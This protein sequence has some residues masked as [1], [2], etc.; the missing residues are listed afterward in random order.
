MTD[1]SLWEVILNGDSPV[2]TRVVEGVLQPVASTTDEHWLARKNEL[3]ACGTAL[4]NLAFVSS[5]HTDSTT[6]SVSAAASIFAACAKLPASPLP[7]VDS[8]KI[9]LRWQMAMLTMQ[10][11]RFLQK[12]GRNLGENGPTSM[13]LDMSK[14]ECYNCRRKGHFAREC[15][16]LKD[17][18]RPGVA[19]PQRRTVPVETLTSNALVSQCNGT[20]SYDW[21]YQA[22]EDPV[23]F[24]LMAFSLNSSSDNETG[25][26]SVE[27]RLLVYKQNE[28]VFEEN[29]KLL[30]IEVELR[31]TAL[32][33]LRHKLEKA[34]Q[35]RDDLKLKLEKF[36]TSS[37]NLT[38]LLASQTNEKPGLG[39]NS[40][41]S[42]T[43][44][45]QDL[46]H[47]TRPSAPIIEDWVS[48][49]KDESETKATQF[50]PSFAESSEHVKSLRHSNQPIETTI[51][52]ATPVHSSPKSNSSGKKRNKKACFVC[53]SVDNLIKDCDYHTKKMA[54]PIPRTY[55]YRGHYKK[56]APLTYS[57]PQK[58]MV[59]PLV[60]TQS[61]PVSNTVIR[62]VSTA[63]P[64]IFVTRPRYAHHVVTKS[65]SPIR[66]H[67]TCSPTLKTST[68]PPRVTTI[69]ASVVSAAQ[70]KQGTWVWRPKCPIL[71]HDFRTT[72]ASMTL[73]WF[74]Y[75]DALGRSN[76]NPNGGK[77][78]GKGKIKTG[79]LDFD[80]VYFVKELKFNLFSVS[81]MCDKKNSVLFTDTEC[82]VLSP[83]FKLSD[84]NQ[85]LHRVPR[86]NNMYNVNLKHIIPSGDLT[87]L[88]AKATLDESNLWHRRLGHIN[89]KTINKLVKGNL[90][91]GLP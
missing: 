27:A 85:V 88:F 83:D 57:K 75:N 55:A 30:N 37:K 70:G 21:S 76:G 65:K 49:S 5:S 87:C 34:K 48:D 40:Q 33:T 24:A 41:L 81:Q 71:D 59:P 11:R 46:S 89:F 29:I 23:N 38:D 12:T 74:D 82:L 4:Q 52:A 69:K 25:L 17:P 51:P 8:L 91:R 19:E 2:P 67:I 1:Y 53:K 78:T 90:V 63:L 20:G 9:D 42:P 35:E 13:G 43:K 77:N 6:D 64:N 36:Q 10:A 58:H 50:V 7:N 45:E 72:S 62:P 73:K 26:E 3:K 44:P 79:K 28:S 61:K 84:D 39:Y 60:L 22:E 66:R 31:D 80:D 16:S 14:V 56:Y 86:E 18:R 15:R 32:V 68:S 47:T 54:Q